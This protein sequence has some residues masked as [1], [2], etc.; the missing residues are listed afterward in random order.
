MNAFVT[1]IISAILAA[2]PGVILRL[3]G[4]FITE[5]MMTEIAQK[6]VGSTLKKLALLT[7]TKSDDE[8]VQFIVDTWK[9]A[10]KA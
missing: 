8:A 2:L 10:E 6:V 9:A 4:P 7:D 1:G 3:V 5:K